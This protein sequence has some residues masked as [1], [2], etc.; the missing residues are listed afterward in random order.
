MAFS[1]GIHFCTSLSEGWGHYIVE[2]MSCRAVVVTTDAPPMSELITPARGV[3][4]PYHHSEPR[5]LGTNFH[6]DPEKLEKNIQ[7]LLL[8]PT[9]EKATLG[10]HARTWFEETDTTFRH[11]LAQTLEDILKS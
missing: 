5:H 3:P 11:K 7:Q 6:A 9:E 10:K 1:H 2:A 8:M 4:V